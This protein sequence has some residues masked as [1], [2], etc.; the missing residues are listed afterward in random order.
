MNN[1]ENCCRKSSYFTSNLF[2]KKNEQ[3]KENDL[4]EHNCHSQEQVKKFNSL[5][6]RLDKIQFFS[7][8]ATKSS[9]KN[10]EEDESDK[11]SMHQSKG[12]LAF[13]I[14]ANQQLEQ[15]H[16]SSGLWQ[17]ILNASVE[18]KI[19][20]ICKEEKDNLEEVQKRTSWL[21]AGLISDIY[22]SVLLY[23]QNTTTDDSRQSLLSRQLKNL[24]NMQMLTKVLKD[25]NKRV[26]IHGVHQSFYPDW[27]LKHCFE[28][29]PEKKSI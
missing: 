27:F 1:I 8:K 18:I 12:T 3:P 7:K 11:T 5:I 28:S 16:D 26:S 22:K 29:N 20:A 14:E 2:P 21:L 25:Q 23:Q 13:Y 9:E 19:D 24:S 15:Q 10:P 4:K 6:A 17:E